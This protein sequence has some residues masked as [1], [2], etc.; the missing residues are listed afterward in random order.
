MEIRRIQM[1]GGSSYIVTLPK[2]WIKSLN[3]KK[4]DQIGL[5]TQSDGTLLVTPKI[6]REQTQKIREFDVS[7]VTNQDYL[8]RRLIGAYIAGYNSI[9]IKSST[10]MSPS[11]KMTVRKFKETTIGQE[12]VEETDSLIIVKDLLNPAE[13]PFDRTIKRMYI[14]VKGMHEDVMT[15]IQ[16]NDKNLIEDVLLRDNEVD[17]LHWLVARQHNII[18]QNVSFAE[19]MG[20]TIEL[21][22]TSFLISRIIER[23]GDHVIRI[24]K[25]AINLTDK[26]ISEDVLEKLESS[27]N[28][29]MDIFNKSI[30]AFLR[31][32]V[33][34]ANETIDTVQKLELKCKEIN[35]MALKQKG[36]YVIS[37][38]YFVESIRRIGEYSADI[39]EN[40][41][42][43]LVGEDK[44]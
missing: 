9:E 43:Y 41:I 8:L 33:K 14:I 27:S 37:L 28:L 10:R 21:A 30:T 1:T 39:S 11:T 7:N 36:E 20:I 22:T 3:I 5:I 35:R 42:N 12:I 38:G 26:K 24:A 31:K 40:V 16:R 19:K 13:M 15:A 44:N 29:A 32:D 34:S 2:E 4:N 17:R 6:D 23:I 18:L 25:N